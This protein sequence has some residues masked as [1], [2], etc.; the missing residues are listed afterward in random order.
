MRRTASEVIRELEL[1]VAR[2]ERQAGS[3]IVGGVGINLGT[4]KSGTAKKTW[5]SASAFFKD[6]NALGGKIS[7][8]DNDED[9]DTGIKDSLMFVAE[10]GNKDVSADPYIIVS[11]ESLL[12]NLIAE[13]TSSKIVNS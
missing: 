9:F 4:S 5:S 1:R 12:L 10:T 8:H 13:G 6:V 11:K 3:P 7:L 2:L